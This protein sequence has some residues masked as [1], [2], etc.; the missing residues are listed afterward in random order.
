MARQQ[1]DLSAKRYVY[2]WAHVI[3]GETL[4][5]EVT[6]GVGGAHGVLRG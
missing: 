1:R 3:L 4:L 6:I 5:R 2:I